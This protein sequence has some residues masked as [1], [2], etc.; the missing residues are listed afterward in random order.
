MHNKRKQNYLTPKFGHP[1]NL[2]LG[3]ESVRDVFITLKSTKAKKNI[4]SGAAVLSYILH[5]IIYTNKGNVE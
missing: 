1:L 3:L 2:L 5:P 4:H